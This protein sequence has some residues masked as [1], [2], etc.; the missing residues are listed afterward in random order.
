[1]PFSIAGPASPALPSLEGINRATERISSGIRTDFQEQAA[2]AAITGRLDAQ[3]GESTIL[4]RYAINQTS[5]LQKADQT[6]SQGKDITERIQEL[7][8]QSS[9]DLLSESDRLAIKA[10]ADGLVQD[11]DS[12]IEDSSFNGRPLFGS[13]TV[14]VDDLRSQ[15]DQLQSGDAFD[16]NLLD[17]LQ[18][19]ITR[20]KAD[21]GTQLNGLDRSIHQ[22][23][24]SS[25]ESQ[26][27][28]LNDTD[29]ASS[30]A[31]LIKEQFL[32]EASVKAF[33]HQKMA[34]SSIM[35]LLN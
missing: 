28:D 10:E 17:E 31:E 21:I 6:L 2:E 25:L 34:E 22:E 27:S 1:M 13:Q 12:L 33:N 32:F 3:I 9:S 35:N 20:T 30:V 8:V 18:N 4:V 7:A 23:F 26:R 11:L 16:Q 24:E 15:L 29:L 5:A 19:E 14:Q